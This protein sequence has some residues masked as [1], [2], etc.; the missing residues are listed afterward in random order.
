MDRIDKFPNTSIGDGGIVSEQFLQLGV[1]RF[2][3]ACRYVH[4]LPYGYNSDRDDLLILF[5]EGFG[6]CTTKHAVIATLAKEIGLPI[7]KHIGIYAMT[8]AIV[9]GTAD[10]LMKWDLP[11]VPMVHCYLVC[12]T[13]RVDLTEGNDNG[14]NRPLDLFLHQEA[15]SANISARDEYL[16]YRK[17]VQTL[18][19]LRPELGGVDLKHILQARE[20]GL[21]L[22]RSKIMP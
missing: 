15:V 14:K 18:L 20:Q 19:S 13:I 6:S 17:A 4:Q 7:E 22:L 8:E 1:T 2:I 12:D 3:D 10:I 11:Y 5:K 21:A 9:T 16:R